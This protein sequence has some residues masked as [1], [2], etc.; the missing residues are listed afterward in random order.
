MK[1][2]D[3]SPGK[4][5]YGF[6]NHEGGSRYPSRAW[7]RLGM[8]AS[9]PA[10][11]LRSKLSPGKTADKA[12][13]VRLELSSG[14]YSWFPAFLEWSVSEVGFPDRLLLLEEPIF[15]YFST[16]SKA[17]AHMKRTLTSFQTP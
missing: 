13:A 7:S 15:M 8:G 11:K 12:S 1:A 10:A 9:G 16:A 2:S 6:H 17:G 14:C 4:K 3:G 5:L